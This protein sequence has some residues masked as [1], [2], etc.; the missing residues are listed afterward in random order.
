MTG[1]QAARELHRRLPQMRSLILTM[2][3]SEQYLEEA[4]RAGASGY[5]V[6]KAADRDLVDACRAVLRGESFRYRGDAGPVDRR[7]DAARERR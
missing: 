2:H 3:E 5:V 7:S 6:K 4:L 1:L